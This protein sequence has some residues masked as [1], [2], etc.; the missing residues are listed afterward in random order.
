MEQ[1][2]QKNIDCIKVF[3]T[4]LANKLSSITDINKNIELNTNLSGQY[5]LIIEGK[6]VHSITDA[7][8]EA[9]ELLDKIVINEFTTIHCLYGLGLGY[10]PDEYIQN[11]KGCI[12]VFEPDIELL[13]FVLSVVDF[14]ETFKTGRLFIVSDKKEFETVLS[15]LYRYKANVTFSF[16]DYYK[17]YHKADIDEFSKYLKRKVSIIDHNYN[18]QSRT[19]Y[20]FFH[21]T[22]DKLSLKYENPL[23]TDYKDLYKDKPAIIVSAG[24]SLHKNIETIKKYQ[25]HALI[26][27]VGTALRTLIENGI[28]PD[29]VNV[30]ESNNTKIHYDVPHR[31]NMIFI[32]EPFTESSYLSMGF[33]KVLTTSSLE[34]D[35]SRWFLETAGKELVNFETKGTV[36]YQAIFSAYSLGC[37][38]IILIGQDLA[39]TDGQCYCKGS[40]FDGLKCVFD[41]ESKKYKIIVDNYDKFK[42]AYCSAI[43]EEYD[44]N[45]LQD[46]VQKRLEELNNNVCSVKGQDGN[47][48]PTDSIYSLFIEYIEDFSRR[49]KDK[50]ILVNASVGGAMIDGFE[51]LPLDKA[52][53]KYA[54]NELD[55]AALTNTDKFANSFDYSVIITNLSKELNILKSI[56]PELSKGLNLVQS[57]QKELR[58]SR[59]YTS[60]ARS[61]SER[62]ISIYLH[63][64]NDFMLKNNAV[65]MLALEQYNEINFLMRQRKSID[66]LESAQNYIELY[67]TYF[68]VVLLKT[69]TAVWFLDSAVK[70]LKERHE[71]C[72]TKS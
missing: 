12:I 48:L 63:I 16:L 56:I 42:T 68:S 53:N 67:H 38:P 51:V 59:I 36:A 25:K 37:N 34:T 31:E 39:Y 28:T 47:L 29:F 1:L 65:K 27:C 17:L 3:N 57:L 4:P 6:P 69:H 45:Y 44:D 18:F 60:K 40:K 11:G 24:P 61:L 50:R 70:E 52:I 26:F 8:K 72:C 54:K 7:Q 35:S 5:N 14:T 71:S 62:I 55:K 19:I 9:K 2:L 15:H 30:I 21:H 22:L 13:S 64:T 66:S 32:A 23:L 10:L 46:V 58:N 49:Y 43:E 33:K 41:D 20:S